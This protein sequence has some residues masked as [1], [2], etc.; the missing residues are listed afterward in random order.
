MFNNLMTLQT[1]CSDCVCLSVY[2]SPFYKIFKTTVISFNVCL[3][4]RPSV[5][6]NVTT[7]LLLD[8]FSLNFIYFWNLRILSRKIVFVKIRQKVPTLHKNE[9][10]LLVAVWSLFVL[11]NDSNKNCTDN[12]KHLFSL[13]IFFTKSWEHFWN[14]G[15]NK[16]KPHRPQCALHVG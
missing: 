7:W 6:P 11:R 1:V 3:L 4:V 13:I 8:E 16:I 10:T 5:R 15:E 2:S 9:Y 12:K 14:N